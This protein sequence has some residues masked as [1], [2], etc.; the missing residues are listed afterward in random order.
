MHF[1]INGYYDRYPKIEL[2]DVP[3]NTCYGIYIIMTVKKDNIRKNIALRSKSDIKL[4]FAYMLEEQ[5]SLLLNC[6]YI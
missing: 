3:C 5:N 4:D 2:K 6:K 1:P